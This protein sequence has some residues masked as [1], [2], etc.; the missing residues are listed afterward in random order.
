MNSRRSSKFLAG[1]VTSLILFSLFSNPALAA[2]G[3]TT[4]VSVASDGTQGNGHSYFHSISADGRYVAFESSASNL[5]NGDTNGADDVF[6]HDRQTGQTTRVSVASDGSQG[7]ESSGYPSISADGRYVAFNSGAS[8]LVSGDTNG[9]NDVFVNDRQTGQTTLVSVDS[10]GSQGNSYSNYPSISAEGRYIAFWSHASNLVSGDTNGTSDIFVHDRQT[11]QT[12]LVSVASDGSKGNNDSDYFSSISADGRYVAF[13]SYSSNLVDG[14]TNSYLDVFVHD[15]QS[16]QTIR[17]SVASDGTQGND[18]S[19]Y[20][21]I[22]ADGRYVAFTSFASN[23]VSGDT[24]GAQDVFIHD[25]QT[26]QTTLVSVD[27][28]GTQGNVSIEPSISADGRYVAFSSNFSTPGASALDIFVHDRQ[29]GQTTRANVASDGTPGNE[30]SDCPAISADGRYVAFSSMANNLVSGDTNGHY[31][32]FVHENDIPFLDLPI[33][34][35]NFSAAA[36]G[37]YGGTGPARVMSW[38]DHNTIGKD[39]NNLD[40]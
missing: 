15:R 39:S 22:S 30:W 6:V 1:L 38:F 31:D 25:R 7:N 28:N 21:S 37:Y 16:G 36:N 29:S 23:L 4:R 10:D 8:N 14:D 19:L 11:G 17:V 35:T 2:A 13:S 18:E 33:Q 12:E 20:P 27:S 24:N 32:V 9:T 26:G 34:Y 3:I 40:G 5:V